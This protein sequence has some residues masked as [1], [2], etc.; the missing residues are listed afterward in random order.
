MTAPRRLSRFRSVLPSVAALSIVAALGMHGSTPVTPSPPAT[1]QAPSP[2]SLAFSAM[3]RLPMRFEENRGQVDESARFVARPRGAN[4]LLTDDGATLALPHETALTLKV[5]GARTVKPR[6]SEPLVTRSNY[7]IGSDRSKWHTDVPNFGRVVYPSVLEGVDLVYHGEEG[8]LE[9]DFVVAPGANASAIAVEVAGASGLSLTA[10]GDLAIHTGRGDVI[11]RRPRVFQSD[12]SGVQH[13]VSATYRLVGPTTIAFEVASYDR[14]RDLVIDPIIQYSTYLGGTGADSAL[15]LSVDSAGNAYITGSSASTNFP[16]KTPFQATNAGF[17]DVFVAKLNNGGS[18]LVYATYIGGTGDEQANGIIVDAA[19]NAHVVGLTDS[20]DF[21]TP[22]GVHAAS[23]GTTDAFVLELAP[24]GGALVYSTYLGGTGADIGR[25]IAVDAAGNTYVSG[26]T[27]ST[28]FATVSPL[29]PANGGGF[30]AFAAK[31]SPD[32]SAVTYA[33]YLGG[34]GDENGNAIAIDALGSAYVA[35]DTNGGA[36]PTQAPLQAAS[37]GVRD[38]FVAKIA[39]DGATLGYATYLGGAGDDSIASIAV[40]V[41]GNAYVAGQTT[42]SDFPTKSPFAPALAGASDAFVAKINAAGA[43][44]VY[45]TYLGGNDLDSAT[46][47]TLDPAGSAYVVGATSSTNFPLMKAPQGVL[48]G[49]SDAFATKLTPGGSALLYSTYLGGSG[50]DSATGIVV[51]AKGDTFV[52]GMTDS[53]NFPKQSA[54]NATNAGGTDA[55]MIRLISTTALAL[56]PATVKVAPL[57]SLKF[58]ATGGTTNGYLF[59]I[60]TNRSGAL[61]DP[62]TGTYTAG[63]I[64]GVVDVVRVRD[65]AGATATAMATVDPSG[66]GAPDAGTPAPTGTGGPPPAP[67]PIDTSDPDAGCSVVASSR[68][69]SHDAFAFAGALALGL[70][71]VAR[72]RRRAD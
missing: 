57:G 40:D 47:V 64:R 5:A 58:T 60:E 44:L 16:M 26:S 34:A 69:A 52:S 21:P 50:T 20:T 65:S 19:G 63:T 70:A 38:G 46:H 25:S 37:G 71:L 27:S 61:M 9:Y 18:A 11:Q 54:L 12:A 8:Q 28:D 72:R 36:F 56:A 7:L 42:S 49:G 17:T 29:Q 22:N 41:G 35:G 43:S 51:D 32:G 31:L 24:T 66:V 23:S 33:T 67:A 55:F 59:D 39:I 2:S 3:A 14:A 53:L 13:D 68:S 62:M 30:D 48:A 15:S 4:L 10:A 6:A 1:A 45:S